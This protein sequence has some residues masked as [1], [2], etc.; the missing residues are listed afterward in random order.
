MKTIKIISLIMFIIGIGFTI[1]DDY[2]ILVSFILI[3]LSLIFLVLAKIIFWI[4]EK[5]IAHQSKDSTN[6]T[7]KPRNKMTNINTVCFS[8]LILSIGLTIFGTWAFMSQKFLGLM[9]L[10][11]TL[12][13]ILFP[14]SLLI[15]AIVK[16]KS[17]MLKKVNPHKKNDLTVTST[18]KP[19]RNIKTVHLISLTMLII[20]A[21]LGVFYYWAT[22]TREKYDI[23]NDIASIIPV[24]ALFLSVIFLITALVIITL[25]TFFSLLSNNK[26]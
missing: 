10:A 3:P 8:M 7:N 11:M 26:K 20:S 16:I 5:F 12:S 25:A 9:F 18:E 15:L 23:F 24:I 6:T 21:G 19:S 4:S 2:G 22:S 13:Y 17:L 14:L 1:V